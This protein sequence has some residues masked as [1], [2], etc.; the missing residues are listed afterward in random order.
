MLILSRIKFISIVEHLYYFNSIVH[1]IFIQIVVID[2]RFQSKLFKYIMPEKS[3]LFEKWQR[4]NFHFQWEVVTRNT[5]VSNA[6]ISF[7]LLKRCLLDFIS[8]E[9][10]HSTLMVWVISPIT[11]N[12]LTV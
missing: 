6:F 12:G 10:Y 7:Q 11:V 4:K 5:F 9:T 3:A 2:S 1:W 8:R